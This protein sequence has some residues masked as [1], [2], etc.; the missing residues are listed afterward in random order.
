MEHNRRISLQTLSIHGNAANEK[1]SSGDAC[2]FG[3]KALNRAASTYV[4]ATM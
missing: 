4:K 2:R 1:A 3:R